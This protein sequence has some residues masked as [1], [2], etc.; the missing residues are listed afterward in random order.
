MTAKSS[1]IKAEIKAKLLE[2][3]NAGTLG[4]VVVDDFKKGV[5]DR[6]YS[7]YPTAVLMTPSISGEV[8]TNVQ[9]LRTYAYEII[10]ISKG[11]DIKEQDEIEELAETLMDVF[12][13]MPSMEGVA[14]GGL[15]PSTSPAEAIPSRSGT[16]IVFSVI[17]KAKAVKDLD[18]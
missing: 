16:Y 1:A 12:D 17:L 11:E 6:D 5:F 7:S 2:L 8:F 15:E 18:L 4:D 14:D 10:V 13:N 9:N 3:K